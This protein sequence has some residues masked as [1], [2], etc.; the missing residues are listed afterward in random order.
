[1]AFLDCLEDLNMT[2]DILHQAEKALADMNTESMINLYSE[3]FKFEDTTSGVVITN[4]GELREYFNR[5]FSLPDVSFTEVN[6]LGFGDRAA[7]EWTWS[8][9]SKGSGQEYSIRGASLFKIKNNRII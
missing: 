9:S 1:M 3:D 7:G 4:Q 2:T 5:L 8:G 6:F